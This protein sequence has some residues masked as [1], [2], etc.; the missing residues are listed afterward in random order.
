MGSLSRKSSA[1]E[2]QVQADL[3]GG[4]WAA[5]E[6]HD[7]DKGGAGHQLRILRGRI[8]RILVDVAPI[9]RSRKWGL[10]RCR[11]QTW[12]AT[13]KYGCKSLN[14]GREG[15]RDRQ[16]IMGH[17]GPHAF[18]SGQLSESVPIA[19]PGAVRACRVAGESGN[20][21]QNDL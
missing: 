6:R 3:T 15:F 14:S 9:L 5:I 17:A 1:P 4:D 11:G 7:I 10:K 18:P 2:S 21:K 16:N 12:C 8:F 19:C 20:S 13:D